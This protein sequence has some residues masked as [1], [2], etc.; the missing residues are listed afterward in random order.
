MWLLDFWG[1]QARIGYLQLRLRIFMAK[2]V[3][4]LAVARDKA[5][6]S[7]CL[8]LEERRLRRVVF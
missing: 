1:Y 6:S 5:G 4:H 7:V 8:G 2:S 3:R